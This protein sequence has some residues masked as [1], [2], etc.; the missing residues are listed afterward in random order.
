M[1]ATASRLRDVSKPIAIVI[2]AGPGLGRSSAL[3][4][5]RAGYDV[6]LVSRREETVKELAEEVT[7]AGADAGWAATD[8]AD[9]DALDAT[10]RRMVEHTGRVDVLHFNPSAAREA[11]ARDL[12]APQL[13]ADLA[14][15][16]AGVLTAVHAALPTLLEQRTGTV[17]VTGS[18]VAD[19]PFPGFASL[20]VQKAAVRNLTQALAADLGPE[21]IHVATVTV[22]GNLTPGTPTG[23]DAVADVLLAL[24]EETAGDPAAW[25]TVVDVS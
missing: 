7:A 15:G 19:H 5:A 14:V 24:T 3:R 11:R 21:G 10:V 4:F 25:R 16:T 9:H 22:R 6:G 13:L 1:S 23:P 12:T 20:G 17:L 8:I 2:G 18:G